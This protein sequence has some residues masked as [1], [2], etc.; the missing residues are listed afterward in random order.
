MQRIADVP[1]KR[2]AQL[3]IGHDKEKSERLKYAP[4]SYD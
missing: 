4:A 3:W 1:G 2:K